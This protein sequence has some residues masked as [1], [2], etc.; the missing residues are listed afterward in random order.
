MKPLHVVT[1]GGFMP[2]RYTERQIP[3]FGF[4]VGFRNTYP[5]SFVTQLDARVRF[6]QKNYLTA[7]GGLFF[8][9]SDL[10]ML[11]K[12]YPIWACGV[13]YARQ[14]LVGPFKLAAQW[15]NVTNFTMYA[16]IGFDF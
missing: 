5:F 6:A 13:E 2:G 9:Y 7:R 1:I 3:F 4:P 15:C 11:F 14:T 16:S 10:S 8:D 12:V